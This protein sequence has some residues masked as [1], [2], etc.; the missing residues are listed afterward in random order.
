MR[1]YLFLPKK[2]RHKHDICMSLIGQIE[3]FIT[4]SKYD[5]LKKFHIHING[6]QLLKG[7]HVLEFLLRSDRLDDHNKVIKRFVVRALLIDICYFTQ[8]SLSCSLK[9]RLSVIDNI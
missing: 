2:Y 7:E 9:K 1:N 6:N 4:D 5:S 8:E 3:E